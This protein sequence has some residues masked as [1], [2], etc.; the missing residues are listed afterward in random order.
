MLF[1]VAADW[2][3]SPAMV[4]GELTGRVLAL[5]VSAPCP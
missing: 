1:M 4:T 3:N 5:D 2:S